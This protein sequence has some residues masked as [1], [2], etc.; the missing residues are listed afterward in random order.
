[1]RALLDRVKI[2]WGGLFRTSPAADA[3]MDSARD[4]RLAEVDRVNA[5]RGTGRFGGSTF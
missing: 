4:R 2:A 5:H 1:M 3:E